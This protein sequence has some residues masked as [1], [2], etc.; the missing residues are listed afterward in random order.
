MADPAP[1]AVSQRERILD[2]ARAIFARRGFDDVTMAE[3]AD[4]AGVA[5]A[6]VFNHFGS[7]HALVEAITAGVLDAYRAMLDAALADER[8]P[9]DELAR[10]LFE[11]MGAGIQNELGFY[12][13]IF[14]EIAKLH[15]GL[16]QSGAGRRIRDANAER[17]ER[18]LA[19]GQARGEISTAFDAR[20]LAAAW[21]ALANG[22]I[23]HWLYE[24]AS[25]PLRER[26]RRAV[27]VFLGPVAVGSGAP[28]GA[29]SPARGASPEPPSRRTKQGGTHG[30][31]SE[32]SRP[33]R[34][35]RARRR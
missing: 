21:D 17:V 29:R 18:L 5:R 25:E 32:A 33:R 11:L 13:G 4:A 15:V 12:R 26:M 8:T 22:T 34:R 6:T 23:T 2:A 14:R 28:A 27:G 16:D 3:I 1:V 24:S 35:A 20:D 19:R 7:K 10:M 31:R 9:T 30:T